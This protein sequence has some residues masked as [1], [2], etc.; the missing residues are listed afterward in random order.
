MTCYQLFPDMCEAGW[1]IEAPQIPPVPQLS[2]Y[3]ACCGA[4]GACQWVPY[5]STLDCQGE[6]LACNWGILND[7]G[8]L[9]CWD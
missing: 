2:E 8:T 3:I 1:C 6:V 9:E 4:G 7:D 5:G